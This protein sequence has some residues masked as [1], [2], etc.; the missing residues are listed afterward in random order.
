MGWDDTT[1]Q[2]KCITVK[3]FQFRKG[4]VFDTQ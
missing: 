4:L 2:W 1:G 3:G